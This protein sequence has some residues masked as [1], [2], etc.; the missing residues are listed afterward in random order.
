MHKSQTNLYSD[1]FS[2]LLRNIMFYIQFNLIKQIAQIKISIKGLLKPIRVDCV[3]R[4]LSYFNE[5]LCVQIKLNYNFQNPVYI[6]FYFN[7][8]IDVIYYPTLISS[9][10]SIYLQKT[11]YQC[12][13]FQFGNC[14]YIKREL[15][16]I[17]CYGFLQVS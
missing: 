7:C 3:A 2:I 15:E 9:S 14:I 5:Q 12:Q 13:F 16:Q 8:D 10:S 11:Y 17:N 6:R 4:S 1:G